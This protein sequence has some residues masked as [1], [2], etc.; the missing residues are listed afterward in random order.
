[1][2]GFELRPAAG[3]RL[4]LGIAFESALAGA[5]VRCHFK[6]G[7]ARGGLSRLE[8]GAQ[9]AALSSAGLAAA[10]CSLPNDI[11]L[12]GRHPTGEPKAFPRAAE[13]Q[14]AQAAAAPMAAPAGSA[15]PKPTKSC[16]KHRPAKRQAGIYTYQE[17]PHR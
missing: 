13:L 3:P 9:A 2:L 1:M 6:A 8:H 5:A 7:T 14:L 15:A 10:G 12:L 4:A 11:W 17:P 16:R